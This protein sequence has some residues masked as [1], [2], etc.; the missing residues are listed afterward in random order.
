MV[1]DTLERAVEPNL[2][3][4]LYLQDAYLH[5]DFKGGNV[6]KPELID[7]EEN[8]PLIQTKRARRGSKQQSEAA[9]TEASTTTTPTG[10]VTRSTSVKERLMH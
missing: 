10:N 6:D 4:R 3:M 9:S 8:N 5:P 7:E 2:N 1:K